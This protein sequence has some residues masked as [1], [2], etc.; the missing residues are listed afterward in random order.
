MIYGLIIVAAVLALVGAGAT[1]KKLKLWIPAGYAKVKA[2][3]KK[4]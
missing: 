1:Y 2:Y 4:A 3:F